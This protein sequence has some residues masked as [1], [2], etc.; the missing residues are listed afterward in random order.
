MRN[1]VS[2]LVAIF[3]FGGTAAVVRGADW[4]QWRGP[5]RDGVAAAEITAWPMTL[6]KQWSVEVGA[7]HAGPLLV[8]ERVYTLT[9][10]GDVEVVQAR[11]LSN[12]SVLWKQQYAAAAELDPVVGWHGVSPKSTPL[13]HNDRLYTFSIDGVV[14]CWNATTGQPVWERSFAK[15]YRKSWP[16]YGTSTSPMMDQ[17][18]L[19]VWVG[20][21]DS[22]A[23]TALDAATGKSV[24]TLAIDGPSYASP[25]IGK[26]AGQEQLV[27]FSQKFLVAVDPRSGKELWKKRFVT[28]Y[29][30]NCVT[31]LIH[32]DRLIYSGYEKSLFAATVNRTNAG[33]RLSDAW[34]IREHP[35]YMSSPVRIGEKLFALS[36]ANGG[37]LIAVDLN[38]GTL[39]WQQPRFGEYAALVAVGT[40]LLVQTDKGQLLVIPASADRYQAARNY[41]VAEGKTWAHP[42]VAGKQILIKDQTHLTCWLVP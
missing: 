30:Q 8:G 28:S 27:T 6:T 38:D 5:N 4:P 2:A 3:L 41:T 1:L 23:L 13:Y 24:W 29:D 32:G 22:G 37:S 26:L 18:R 7:G 12:G 40:D 35:L 19:I 31:P 33:F 14:R 15:T 20:G 34:E 21:H 11:K 16:L 17:D 39:L 42:A 25:V 36:M 9:R 10:V